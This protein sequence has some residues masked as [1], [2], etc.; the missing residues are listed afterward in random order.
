MTHDQTSKALLKGFDKINCEK[1]NDAHQKASK[2]DLLRN[3]TLRKI[4]R[5]SFSFAI[6]R[7]V[8]NSVSLSG[9]AACLF[10]AERYEL[11]AIIM[12][13]VFACV[14]TDTEKKF[15]ETTIHSA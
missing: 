7:K 15:S 10:T 11:G 12:S 3:L 14:L 9:T 1:R 6:Q 13:D 8:Y 2:E 4:Q 5:P